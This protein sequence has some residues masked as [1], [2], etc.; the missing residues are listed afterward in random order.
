MKSRGDFFLCQ[1]SQNIY[2]I[3][4]LLILLKVVNCIKNGEFAEIVTEEGAVLDV[5]TVQN[6]NI[7]SIEKNH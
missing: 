6:I 3:E 7:T 2:I 1:E 5:S 4:K